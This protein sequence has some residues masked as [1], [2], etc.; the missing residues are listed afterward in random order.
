ME[1]RGI[2]RVVSLPYHASQFS[3]LHTILV[4][5]LVV[6]TIYF[7]DCYIHKALIL[8]IYNI[9]IPSLQRLSPLYPRLQLRSSV[10]LSLKIEPSE[11][12]NLR[13]LKLSFFRMIDFGDL[14]NFTTSIIQSDSKILSYMLHLFF[15]IFIIYLCIFIMNEDDYMKYGLSIIT[16]REKFVD[17]LR[18]NNFWHFNE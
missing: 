12:V 16:L 15:S 4:S 17:T 9:L 11:W 1:R 2:F 13:T 6:M 18:V 5:G 8:L 3:A 14:R 10:E 7:D